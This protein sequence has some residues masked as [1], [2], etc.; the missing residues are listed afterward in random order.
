MVF[1][2]ELGKENLTMLTDFYE[3]TMANGFLESGNGERIFY[4]D[5]FFR[6]IPDGGGLAIM[7]GVEQVIRYIQNLSFSYDYEDN[8]NYALNNVSLD[9]ERGSYTV[10]VGHNG[11]GKSTLAKLMVGLLKPQ[12]GTIKIN[13]TLLTEESID[14]LRHHIGIV[15]KNPDNQ[16]VG[17]TVKDDIAFGLENRNIEPEVMKEKI[18]E[19]SKKVSM[20]K[21]LEHNPEQLSGG[22]KQR[23]AIAGVLAINPEIIIFDEA[24]SMLD[25]KGVSEIIDIINTIKKEKTIISITHNL[26]EAKYA[27]RVIVMNKG[28]IVLNDTPEEVFKH[29][30]I[31]KDSN[32]DILESMKLLEKIEESSI[33]RKEEIKEAL[34][35][36][37]YQK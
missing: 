6:T 4:F 15:F 29:V 24:T 9:I 19:Y 35:E 2:N 3:L 12:E 30:D 25:P 16:F 10:I 14:D 13:N 26:N 8:K 1:T 32:L 34:W 27:D 11:S 23:V 18:L 28:K 20:D 7:A 33:H 37:S 5:M 22:E 31:L 17:V 21:F 36:L